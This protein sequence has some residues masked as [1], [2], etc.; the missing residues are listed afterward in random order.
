MKSIY[1]ANERFIF[2]TPFY[3]FNNIS[4]FDKLQDDSTYREMLQIATPDLSNDLKKNENNKNQIKYSSYR[5]FQRACIR[6]TPFGLFAGCSVGTIGEQTQVILFGQEMYHRYTRLDMNYICALIQHI[7]RDTKIREQLT[8][9]PNTSLYPV[10]NYLRY[11][12]SHYYKTRRI[13]QTASIENTEYLQ[14][15]LYMAE[16]GALFSSLAI[17]LVDDDIDIDE[18]TE[19]IHELIDVQILI[20]ELEPSVTNIAPL[21]MLISQ[22]NRLG[23]VANDFI[24]LLEK[25]DHKLSKIDQSPIGQTNDIY[26]D[27]IKDIKKTKIDIE[28]KYL[29]QTDLFQPAQHA[30]VSRR[31]ITDIQKTLIF[32]NKI[33]PSS[34]KTFLAQFKENFVK[35]YEEREM[36]LLYVLDNEIGI[37]HRPNV[38]SDISPLVDDLVVQ[39]VYQS[40]NISLMGFQNLMLQKYQKAFQENNHE[41]ILTDDDV[42]NIEPQW[43][44]LPY[45]ISVMCQILKDN[46]TG[47]SIFIKSVGGPSAANLLGRFCHLN[48]QILCHTL[49]ITEKETQANPDVIFAEIVHLPESRMGNILLRPV[50]RPY[51]ISYLARSGVSKEFEIRLSDLYLSVRNKRFVLRSKRLNKE[52]IPRMSTAHNYSGQN[53]MPVYHFLCDMQHQD[54]RTGL[55]FYWNEIFRYFDFLPRVI[56][57]NCILSKACWT[58]QK[59]EIDPFIKI[60]NDDELLEKIQ[61][62]L[63][64]R[65]IPQEVFLSDG[66]N[67]LYINMQK[68]LSIRAWLSVVKKRPAFKL[69]E[70]LFN[71]ETAVIK[72]PDGI[73]TN[74][75]IFAFYK[76]IE[77]TK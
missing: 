65:N 40:D 6:P 25:I 50:L 45:T 22:L 52:I 31:L 51:E 10:G 20:S 15:V 11:V 28:F 44:D 41:I 39:Q 13:H 24:L 75:F 5:Y 76:E 36:P 58:V 30:T 9:Y 60:K 63:C 38:S 42:K 70:T 59:K 48:E 62:W 53:S 8:Y 77:K 54:G 2:R 33:T 26:Y 23:Q 18:A 72:G 67:E 12:E 56:Y 19:F 55:S 21:S 71:P 64:K 32:L 3:P 43:D 4:N 47:K 29:F 66:D 27:I 68:I 35:R 17:S 61:I 37:G 57:G 1:T 16:N 69:E 49:N 7:E 14:K 74:E 34:P 46:N 73:F